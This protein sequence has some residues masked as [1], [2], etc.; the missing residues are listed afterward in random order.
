MSYRGWS[1]LQSSRATKKAAASILPTLGLVFAGAVGADLVFNVGNEIMSFS[2]PMP[3]NS[4][5]VTVQ[6]V[7][8]AIDYIRR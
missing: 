7:N 2:S 1:D 6:A 3:T 4:T 5:P 8:Y